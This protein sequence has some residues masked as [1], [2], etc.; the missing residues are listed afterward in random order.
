MR[1]FV[2]KVSIS[3]KIRK[4][5]TASSRPCTTGHF[6]SAHIPIADSEA[7]PVRRCLEKA[8]VE[9]G[10]ERNQWKTSDELRKLPNCLF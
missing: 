4:F 9:T 8:H 10:V 5:V 2:R 3:G 7:V 1:I 6:K